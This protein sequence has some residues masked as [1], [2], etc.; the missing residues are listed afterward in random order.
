[1]LERNEMNSLGFFLIFWL[2]FDQN[3]KKEILKQNRKY[4]NFEPKIGL[5][6]KI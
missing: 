4:F 1:M 2:K 6:I 3:R 5:K